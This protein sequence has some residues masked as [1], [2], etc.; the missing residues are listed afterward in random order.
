MSGATPVRATLMSGVVRLACWAGVPAAGT[1][2]ARGV[3]RGAV[4][5]AGAPPAGGA[6]ASWHQPSPAEK[7]TRLGTSHASRATVVTLLRT[8]ALTP[9]YES[10]AP[11]I[12]L[13]R[14]PQAH[15]DVRAPVGG[16]TSSPRVPTLDKSSACTVPVPTPSPFLHHTIPQ[17]VAVGEGTQ[18]TV[19]WEPA[20][21]TRLGARPKVRLGTA[22]GTVS[23]GVAGSGR[24]MGESGY[25][26]SASSASVPD[27]FRAE[28]GRHGSPV[29]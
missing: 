26:T 14:R 10:G 23:G 28:P 19:L 5:G 17:R 7:A 12:Q 3:P 22:G 24:T 25:H 11:H 13:T 9:E 2:G 27:G 18:T 16:A 4:S 21:S 29:A 20:R 1:T 8:I 6:T 15:R